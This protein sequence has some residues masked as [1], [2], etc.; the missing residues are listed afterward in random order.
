MP[1]CGGSLD[2]YQQSDW[3]FF[4]ARHRERAVSFKRA[5]E[6]A[7]NLEEMVSLVNNQFSLLSGDNPY[8]QD[9]QKEKYQTSTTAWRSDG[10][11][12]IVSN[13]HNRLI[14]A[15]KDQKSEVAQVPKNEA[16]GESKCEATQEDHG[17]ISATAAACAKR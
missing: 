12:K 2:Q 1:K 15:S 11:F 7:S 14:G 6:R 5:L 10:F 4:Y 16:G 3:S 8:P 9:Q 17:A 13:S